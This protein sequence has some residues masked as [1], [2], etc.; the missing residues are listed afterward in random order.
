MEEILFWNKLNSAYASFCVDT[1]LA[2]KS[3]GYAELA[4]ALVGD[5]LEWCNT[6]ALLS[7]TAMQSF[8][9]KRIPELEQALKESERQLSFERETSC[10]LRK[11]IKDAN[12]TAEDTMWELQEQLAHATN[13]MQI[14]RDTALKLRG[15]LETTQAKLVEVEMYL[16]SER[17]SVAL[18]LEEELASAK[19][20]IAELE[21]D[22]DDLEMKIKD[23]KSAPVKVQNSKS[24]NRGGIFAKQHEVEAAA[25][26]HNRPHDKENI[27]F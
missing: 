14:E 23:R 21:E 10:S 5:E 17:G 8:L 16:T 3:G 18:Q 25:A 26:L 24:S 6:D 9:Q 4:T 11:Q 13:T 22:K 15:Q 1:L 19:L 27:S 12:I 20:R 7:M 2:S